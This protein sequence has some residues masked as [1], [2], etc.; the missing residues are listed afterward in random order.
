M[1]R[2]RVI[3]L[4][5]PKSGTTTLAR[6]LRKA[7]LHVADHRIKPVQTDDARPPISTSMHTAELLPSSSS[8]RRSRAAI[9]K[10]HCG[11]PHRGCTVNQSRARPCTYVV[12]AE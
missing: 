6:A 11:R 8:C 2:L 4:G 1:S 12:N 7:G 3:N 10:R 5:L 9:A